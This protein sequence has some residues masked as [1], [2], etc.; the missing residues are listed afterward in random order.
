MEFPESKPALSEL[1]VRMYSLY[2]MKL[3]LV[4]VMIRI[5]VVSCEG[6]HTY[7]RTVGVITLHLS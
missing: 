3:V 4:I 6:V 2:C 1:K 7:V 5:T